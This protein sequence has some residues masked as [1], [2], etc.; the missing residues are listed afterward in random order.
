MQ[1]FPSTD[2]SKRNVNVILVSLTEGCLSFCSLW[3]SNTVFVIKK[4]INEDVLPCFYFFKLQF[5]FLDVEEFAK[6]SELKK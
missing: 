6:I 5:S 3:N 4:R 2:F 1:H